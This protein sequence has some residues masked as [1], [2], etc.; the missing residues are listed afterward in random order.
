M[1]VR[2]MIGV[3]AVAVAAAIGIGIAVSRA[4]S[5]WCDDFGDVCPAEVRYDD[6]MYVVVC[7]DYFVG[8][9]QARLKNPA[10]LRDEQLRVRCHSGDVETERRAW[11]VDGVDPERS[12]CSTKRTPLSAMVRRSRMARACPGGGSSH[13]AASGSGQVEQVACGCSRV[14][15]RVMEL[16]SHCQLGNRTSPRSGE[17]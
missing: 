11:T 6:R 4:D 8:F 3:F 7:T 9:E 14:V 16:S 12:L 17:R 1:R 13:A 10:R 2:S 15:G 5:P